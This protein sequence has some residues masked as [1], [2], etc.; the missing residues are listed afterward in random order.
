VNPAFPIGMIDPVCLLMMRRLYFYYGCSNINPIYGVELDPVTFNPIGKSK[1]LFNSPKTN[2]DGNGREITTINQTIPGLKVLDDQH[3]GKYYLQY[4][5]PG[6]EFKSYCDGQYVS[7]TPLGDYSLASIIL[8]HP[9][10]KD[11]LAERTQ[12]YVQDKY[13]NYWHI[14]TMTIS[15]NICLRDARLFPMF[16][17]KDGELYTIPVLA[18]SLSSFPG[19]KYLVLKKYHLAG[20]CFLQ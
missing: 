14:S 13:G 15:Q 8:V 18:I 10:P 11:L 2:T 6:T 17:D 19:K 9:N 7:D 20:R 1:V 16:F 12:Q 5:I 3:N 4:A